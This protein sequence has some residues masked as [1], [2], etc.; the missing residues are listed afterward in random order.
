[1]IHKT[2]F[3]YCYDGITT[4]I[5]LQ[6]RSFFMLWDGERW[7]I[8]LAAQENCKEI[9]LL[10]RRKTMHR[11]MN[12]FLSFAACL[13]LLAV[14]TL[15]ITPLEARLPLT[16]GLSGDESRREGSIRIRGESGI[17]LALSGCYLLREDGKADLFLPGWYARLQFRSF[18]CG[19]IC[20]L[21]E[22]PGGPK[23]RIPVRAI[24][25]QH[26]PMLDLGRKDVPTEVIWKA[27]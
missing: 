15:S 22:L 21:L 7:H 23:G 12:L 18:L 19:R 5:N 2:A 11:P 27:P 1:M 3:S 9:F 24:Y 13:L 10:Q 16:G 25:A 14:I 26:V 6:R 4:D 20:I 8:C 17:G